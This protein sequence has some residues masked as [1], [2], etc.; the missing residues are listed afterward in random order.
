MNNNQQMVRFTCPNCGQRLKIQ[1][2]NAGR[3]CR[4]TRCPTRMKVPGQ[5]RAPAARPVVDP[6]IGPLPH[7]RAIVPLKLTLPK[8]MGGMETKVSQTTA[9][10]IAKVAA[11]GL[12]AI[13]GVV[14]GAYFC[15]RRPSA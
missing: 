15:I 2:T 12:L 7:E 4:C 10:N 8:N 13:L 5:S 1:A 9:N 14:V 11:G 3:L 6:F